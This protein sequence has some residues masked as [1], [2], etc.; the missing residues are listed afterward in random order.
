MPCKRRVLDGYLTSME[1]QPL[2]V[3][4][5]DLLEF[6]RRIT[7]GAGIRF[8]DLTPALR[9]ETEEGRLTY[10]AIRDTHLNRL[11]SLAVG[12]ALAEALEPVVGAPPH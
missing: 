4:Q 2:P 8:V 12:E 11:G 6:V 9:K 3:V 5:S 1:G 7:T 10:N